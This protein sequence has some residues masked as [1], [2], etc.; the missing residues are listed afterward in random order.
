MINDYIKDYFFLFFQGPLEPK[1][2][3]QEHLSG[4]IHLHSIPKVTT[5]MCLSYT[6]TLFFLQITCAIHYTVNP[7][8]HKNKL[9]INLEYTLALRILK[10]HFESS[11]QQH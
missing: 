8:D 6:C 9:L 2:F 1:K 5:G 11:T 4:E 10:E 7:T 3:H